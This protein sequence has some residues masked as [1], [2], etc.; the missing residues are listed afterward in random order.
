MRTATSAELTRLS[1][2]TFNVAVKVELEDQTGAWR[3]ITSWNGA[4]Y[5]QSA[6]WSRLLDQPVMS[7]TVTL[8]RSIAGNSIAPG[9]TLSPLNQSG[10]VYSPFIRGGQKIRISTACTDAGVAPVAGDWKEVFL[11]RVDNPDWGGKPNTLSIGISDQGGWLVQT[12]IQDVK[13]YS[14]DAGVPVETI[15][16]QILDDN[17]SAKLGRVVLYTPTSPGWNIR[18]FQQAQT[19]VLDAVRTL[20]QQIGWD[21]RFQY[22]AANAFRLTFFQPQRTKTVADYTFGPNVYFDVTPV[23]LNTD[24]IRNVIR[25]KFVDKT[26]GAVGQSVASDPVSIAKYDTKFMEMSF[27]STSNIDTQTEADTLTAAVLSDLS[28][29]LVDQTMRSTYFWVADLGDLYGFTS[30]GEIFDVTNKLAVVGIEHSLSREKSESSIQVRG[31]PAGAYKDWLLNQ[32]ESV[33]DSGT[34]ADDVDFIN[35]R[36]KSRDANGITQTWDGVTPLVSQIWVYELTLTNPVTGDPFK[37]QVGLVTPVRYDA[38]TT[39]QFTFAYPPLNSTKYVQVEL[40]DQN[41]KAGRVYRLTIQAAGSKPQI[42]NIQQQIAVSGSFCSMSLD[43][44]DALLKGGT[45]RAWVNASSANDGDPT[46]T[47]DTVVLA[48][49]PS[50]IDSTTTFNLAG[51]GTS[52]LL[53]N[54]QVHQGRG[55]RVFFEFVN[56]DGVSSGVQSFTLLSTGGIIDANGTLL[57]GVI[58]TALQFASSV[59]PVQVFATT[60]PSSAPDGT[61]AFLTADGKIY[62]R[63]SGAWVST[64]PTV[65][66]TGTIVTSQIADAALTVA[67]FAAGLRPVRIVS[68]LP[69]SGDVQGDTVFLTTDNKLYRWTGSAWTSAVAA[70]DLSGQINTAQIADAAITAAKIGAAAVGT[71]ALANAAVT[72]A[73]IAAGAV[74]T[75]SITDGSVSTAKVAANAI[76]AAKIAAGTITS[77]EIAANTIVAGNIAAGTITTTQIASA[78]IVAGNIAAATITTTQIAAATIVAANIASGTITTSLIAANQITTGLMAAGAITTTE[79]AAA[80]VTAAKIAAGTITANEIA[81]A[82]ITGAKIAAAAIIGANI[83]AGTITASNIAANTITAGLIAAGAITTSALAAGAVTTTKISVSVLSGISS[84]MGT[85]VAGRLNSVNGQSYMDLNATGTNPFLHHAD[86]GGTT[87]FELLANGSATFYGTVAST[88]FTGAGAT[89]SGGGVTVSGG[90]LFVSTTYGIIFSTTSAVNTPQ[91]S[92]D[93]T[94]ILIIGSKSGSNV[95]NG[96]L[97]QYRAGASFPVSWPVPVVVVTA[98]APSNAGRY[99]LGDLWADNTAGTSVDLYVH[100]GT[101][102]VLTT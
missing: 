75:T 2:Q 98:A 77:N 44:V 41:L 21:V 57:N 1:A 95:V 79:L 72:N 38:A 47:P 83:A 84:D 93:G 53:A 32:G 39:T 102:F 70:V 17:Q 5:F 56:T 59:Q 94:N 43:I 33:G 67:K 64:V 88:S 46:T 29:P 12:Q 60:L 85:I 66:L 50:H 36:E 76:T 23:K 96:Q 61:F 97:A 100:D 6:N 78:T 15:M 10:G 101:S 34:T 11:G 52:L 62:R 63:V 82:T 68:A 58:T 55:K 54:V 48:A 13:T 37:T 4:N 89:F 49:T 25:V 73:I 3:D 31:V 7:G 28:N 91:I 69:A 16:Q 35:W 19:N 30:N 99:K 90:F 92:S 24:D 81:G 65:D 18:T 40:R 27:D 86:S 80:A 87:Q 51:G 20:A 9:V 74:T 45:L 42:M 26:T 71:A 14:T 8:L 22:D